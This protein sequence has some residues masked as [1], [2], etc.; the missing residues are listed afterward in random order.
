MQRNNDVRFVLVMRKTR[1][2]ELIERFNT[3]PQA[4]FYLEHNH[5]E[6]SDY[7][8]EH[9]LYQ[10]QLIQ[11]ESILKS[12]G[13]F[14]LLER[15]LLPS[16]QFSKHDIVIVI[17]QDGLVANTLK[18]LNGQ[19]VIAINPDPERWD[20]QLLPFEI[21]QLQEVVMNTLKG[22]IEQKM[23]TFAQATTND[24]QSL[25]AV[26]DLFIGPKSH[27]SARY[28]LNWNG[29]QE[30]QS[31]SGIII[32]TGLGST[33]WFQSILAGAQ[34]IMGGNNHPLA[35]GF[36][37]GESK[38]QFSVRE[39]FLSKTTGTRWVFGT[40]EP[41]SPLA[42]ESLMPHNGVIFSD[43]IEDDFLQFNS[44]CIVTVKIAD[45]QGLLVA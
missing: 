33:G 40:I 15:K 9:D 12:L 32:S 36:G 8:N 3:W 20:G 18:Y 7:L 42:V 45:L 13:R 16:Y 41:G 22:K 31:S 1:L 27:T 25:L 39:P 37:W 11:A 21:G 5:V 29:E 14:Q 10:R 2:Q 35:K 30:F 43:G 26:N 38:L 17:G 23:V 34:A 24:G 28:L 44:G 19:P 4:K 6:V